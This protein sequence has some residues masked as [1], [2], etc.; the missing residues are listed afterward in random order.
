[1]DCYIYGSK[2]WAER[3]QHGTKE[4]F[5][6]EINFKN[7]RSTVWSLAQNSR[8]LR[9][10]GARRIQSQSIVRRKKKELEHTEE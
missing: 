1:M 8:A 3:E 7:G 10:K 9:Y 2:Q 5:D 4:L 6:Q